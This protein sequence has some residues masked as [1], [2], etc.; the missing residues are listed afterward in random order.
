M[1]EEQLY[2]ILVRYSRDGL[3]AYDLEAGNLIAAVAKA[4]RFK[5]Q[6]FFVEIFDADGNSVSIPEQ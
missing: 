5:P 4:H 1:T 2:R 6:G 3:V